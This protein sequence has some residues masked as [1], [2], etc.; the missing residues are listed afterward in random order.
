MKTIGL[1]GGMSWESTVP[2]YEII[3]KGI[4]KTLGKNHSA[5][6][7]V[8]SVDF[9]EIEELQY[10]GDWEQLNKIIIKS[11]LSLKAAGADFIVLCTNTMHK[12]VDNFESAVGL[13]LIHIAD[14][15]GETITKMGIK[16]IGLLG[17]IFTMEQDFYKEKLINK[18]NLE[19]VIPNKDNRHIINDI[20]YKELVKGI[21]NESSKEKYLRIMDTMK[22]EHIQGIILGC[23]EIGLLVNQYSLPLFDS[24]K[25]HAE[26]AVEVMLNK[27]V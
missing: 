14:A 17:T 21:I 3:N 27:V 9:Q 2:Y 6:C 22:N 18:Y 8:Y 13:P 15:I 12:V 10:S 25:I 11:G 23:T 16:K 7:I 5:K 1:I 20:I 19:V 26:K 4:N 24:T